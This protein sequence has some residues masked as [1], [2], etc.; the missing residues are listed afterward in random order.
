MNKEIRT[1]R[2][3]LRELYVKYTKELYQIT[4]KIDKYLDRKIEKC[5]FR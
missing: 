5:I 4:L 3:H 1:A 2:K